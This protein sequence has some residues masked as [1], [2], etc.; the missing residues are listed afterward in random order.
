MRPGVRPRNCPLARRLACP[1][2]AVLLGLAAI[3]AGPSVSLARAEERAGPAMRERVQRDRPSPQQ[4]R[5]LVS[6]LRDLHPELAD[7]VEAAMADNP[8]QVRRILGPR[9]RLLQRLADLRDDDPEMY[10]LRAA[11]LRLA[12]RAI[13][14]AYAARQAQRAG[15]PEAAQARIAE[16]RDIVTERFEVKTDIRRLELAQL[17]RRLDELQ[18]ELDERTEAQQALIEAHVDDLLQRDEPPDSAPPSDEETL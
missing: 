6:V 11:D 10:R 8:R 15:E 12:R 5:E 16:L 7:R 3:V 17:E 1:V 9:W 18:A 4:V 13:E 2:A 14:V